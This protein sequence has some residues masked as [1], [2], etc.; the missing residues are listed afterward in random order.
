[1]VAILWLYINIYYDLLE[2]SYFIGNDFQLQILNLGVRDS[3]Y[4]ETFLI[5]MI[6][7]KRK[8]DDLSDNHCF[9]LSKVVSL[10]FG[11]PS[12]S[13]FFPSTKHIW[14]AFPPTKPMIQVNELAALDK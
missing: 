8:Y 7:Y 14:T 10:G 11:K 1:M 13:D 3:R 12:S 4:Q 6:K 9:M 5:F 2:V